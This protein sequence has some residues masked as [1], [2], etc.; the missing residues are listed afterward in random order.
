MN[1]SLVERA[2]ED[3][4]EISFHRPEVKSTPGTDKFSR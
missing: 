4:K 3:Q 1:P 2:D